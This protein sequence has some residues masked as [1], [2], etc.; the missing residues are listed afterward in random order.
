MT[1]ASATA[2]SLAAP[3]PKISRYLS[4][5]AQTTSLAAIV[6]FLAAIIV[7]SIIFYSW[8]LVFLQVASAWDVILSGLQMVVFTLLPVIGAPVGWVVGVWLSRRSKRRVWQNL[9]LAY[10]TVFYVISVITPIIIGSPTWARLFVASIGV[11]LVMAVFEERRHF[12][13]LSAFGPTEAVRFRIVS[14][15][16]LGFTVFVGSLTNVIAQVTAEGMIGY[17]SVALTLP[18]LPECEAPRAVW[19]GERAVVA[20]CRNG[21]TAVVIGSENV[22][23]ELRRSPR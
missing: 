16:M 17:E 7:N 5:V 20:K 22:V 6:G 1:S 4:F 15:A 12:R 3:F 8:G 14:V 9:L 21:R 11:M 13:R 2:G 23:L 10:A 18:A 19:I